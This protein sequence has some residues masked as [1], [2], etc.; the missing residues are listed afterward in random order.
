M[1]W[2]WSADRWRHDHA[3]AADQIRFIRARLPLGDAAVGGPFPSVLPF[4]RSPR[5]TAAA[6]NRS[7]E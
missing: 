2:S 6:S 3:L 5:R 7:T 1:S 4:H